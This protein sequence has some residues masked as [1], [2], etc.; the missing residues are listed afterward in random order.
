VAVGFDA[1]GPSAA[2]QAGAAVTSLSWSHTAVTGPAAMVTSASVALTSGTFGA[3]CAGTAMTQLAKQENA[4]ASGAGNTLMF[5]LPGVTAGTKTMT[6]TS[7]ASSDME[8]GSVSYAGADPAAPFGTPVT[9][10]GNTA[11]ATVTVPGTAAT[12]MIA[13]VAGSGSSFTALPAG[14]ARWLNNQNSSSGGGN[15]YGT[16]TGGGGA[17]TLTWTISGTDFWGAIGAEIVAAPAGPT[18]TTAVLPDGHLGAAYSQTLTQ[19]GGAAPV[20]WAVTAGSLPA[21]L[22]LAGSAGVIS[23]TPAATGASS[24]T[25]QVTDS[26]SATAT[27]ALTIT[28]DPPLSGPNLPSAG[29]DLGGGT[30]SWAGPGNVTADD[31]TAAVWTVI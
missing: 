4:G 19:T 5:G 26:A 21:G 14:T 23:G 29:A 1:V 11:S 2:G 3:T 25:V 20:T 10:S 12:S 22:T 27:A 9:N 7:S 28:I 18:V 30:G 16:D 13:A 15:G 31:G 6:L 24:F 17:G 8:A